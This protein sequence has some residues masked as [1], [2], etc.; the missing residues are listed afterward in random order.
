MAHG[1]NRAA[2]KRALACTSR[3]F[4]VRPGEWSNH[5]FVV[6][7]LSECARQDHRS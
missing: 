6:D 5:L 1:D 7:D 2:Y 4:V 3:L